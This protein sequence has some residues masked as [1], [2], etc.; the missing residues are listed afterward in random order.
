MP[1]SEIIKRGIDKLAVRL[2]VFELLQFFHPLFVFDAFHLH[3]GHLLI[4]HLVELF[5]QDD[6][7]VFEDGLDER[8]QNERVF[9]RLRVH[10][11]NRFEQIQ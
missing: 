8:E 7:R 1:R 6:V 2:G 3:L 5:A 4:L 11:R 9:R 10:E